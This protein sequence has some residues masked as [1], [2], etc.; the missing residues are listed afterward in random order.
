MSY[1]GTDE[2]E[3]QTVAKPLHKFYVG[4]EHIGSAIARGHNAPI[5]RASIGEAIEDARKLLHDNPRRDAVVIVEIIRIVRRKEP[6]IIV[7]E[8]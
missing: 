1:H 6:P 4:A 2:E 5:V 3:V 8:V 7:E